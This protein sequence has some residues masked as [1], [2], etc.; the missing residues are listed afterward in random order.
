MGVPPAPR[1][2]NRPEFQVPKDQWIIGSI[3]GPNGRGHR[4]AQSGTYVVIFGWAASTRPAIRIQ[5]VVVQIDGKSIGEQKSFSPRPDVAAAY[6]RPDFEMSGWKI[7]HKL[8]GYSPGEHTIN[9][10]VVAFD[11]QASEL[12]ALKMQ[13]VE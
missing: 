4:V 8:Q 7:I 2:R 10:Q 6:A 12:P 5:K 9:V 11:G 13:V 1:Q 3:D